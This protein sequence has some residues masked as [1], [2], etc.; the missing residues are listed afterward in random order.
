MLEPIVQILGAVGRLNASVIY[1]I[2]NFLLV[3]LSQVLKLIIQDVG[4]KKLRRHQTDNL[5]ELWQEL[6]F[7]LEPI[8]QILGA[9]GRLNAS[10]IYVISNFLLVTSS[11]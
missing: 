7:M 2:S 6:I 8:V 11:Q 1:V 9:V 3:T 4:K 10:V 5:T